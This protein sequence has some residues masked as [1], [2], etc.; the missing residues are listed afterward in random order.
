MQELS[1]LEPR[2]GQ[3]VVVALIG[4]LA[5]L[6][7]AFV[8][9]PAGAAVKPTNPTTCK[10]FRVLHDDRIGAATFPAGTYTLTL[11]DTSLNCK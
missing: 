11:Q 9:R 2:R 1:R 3:I 4:M 5:A 6:A 8:A 7:L 10:G